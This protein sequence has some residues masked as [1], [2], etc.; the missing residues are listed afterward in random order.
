MAEPTLNEPQ[1]WKGHWWLPEEPDHRVAGI[2]TYDPGQGLHLSLIGGWEYRVMTAIGT[3]GYSVSGG[4][5]QWPMILGQVER[6]LVTVLDAR[7]VKARSNLFDAP[8]SPPDVLELG[9]NTALIGCHL[10]S[11]D[12]AAFVSGTATVEN[13]TAWLP[14]TSIETKVTW[15]KGSQATGA[16][17]VERIEPLVATFGDIEIKMHLLSW[18]PSI[19]TTRAATIARVKEHASIE[20]RSP[21]GRALM[22]WIRH[23]SAVADLMSFSTLKACG[24]IAMRVYLPATP[25]RYPDDYPLRDEP[26]KVEV[27]SRRHVVPQPD[28]PAVTDLLLTPNDLPFADLLPG[29][30]ALHDQFSAARGMILGLR[31][32]TGGYIETRV[33]TAVA[34]AEAMHRALKLGPR[35]PQD[36]FDELK[37]LLMGAIPARR[38]P[39]L[40]DMLGRNEPTLK[41]RLLALAK[42]PGAVMEMLVP[43]PE[44]WARLAGQA[45]NKLAHEGSGGGGDFRQLYAIVE[46]TAAVVVLNMLHE[47][48]VPEDRLR[49]AITEH[50]VLSHA[51]RLARDELT[52]SG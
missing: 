33:V 47:L 42:R 40:S 41:Q 12:E 7:T 49:R 31:Y 37:N 3:G 52:Q 11:P 32:V 34:A 39:W 48:G 4:F 5:Q 8:G 2:L 38:K 15:T 20:L 23:F 22:E 27:Y 6:Q 26:H 50:S 51:A 13:L 28:A 43:D 19:E 14:R 29:W 16:I 18:L 1:S 17:E 45:R 9:A 10:D 25:D 44:T 21:D 36:E 24:L 46:V 30:L 35:I